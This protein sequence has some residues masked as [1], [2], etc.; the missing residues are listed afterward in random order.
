M[1]ALRLSFFMTSGSWHALVRHTVLTQL[2]FYPAIT[3]GE[4]NGSLMHATVGGPTD[5]DAARG[6]CD[7]LLTRFCG[8]SGRVPGPM[9]CRAL[10]TLA[11]IGQY[12]AAPRLDIAQAGCS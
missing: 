10:R 11:V 1:T 3:S 2:K 8:S 6:A 7:R 9:R 5:P 4:F 12:V